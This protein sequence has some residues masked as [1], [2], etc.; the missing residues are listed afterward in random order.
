MFIAQNSAT[1]S[2]TRKLKNAGRKGN[3]FFIVWSCDEKESLIKLRE[4]R[5]DISALTLLFVVALG[6]AQEP[7]ATVNLFYGWIWSVQ[8]NCQVAIA[9]IVTETAKSENSGT[10]RFGGP[11]PVSSRNIHGNKIMA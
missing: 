10:D 2:G 1:Q 6:A 5:R 8:R 4:S 11:L 3:L 9:L 7:K